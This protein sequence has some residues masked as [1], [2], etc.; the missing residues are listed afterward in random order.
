MTS[1][2]T[3]TIVA[4]LLVITRMPSVHR[5]GRRMGDEIVEQLCGE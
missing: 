3:I 1:L 2:R 4:T 5:L